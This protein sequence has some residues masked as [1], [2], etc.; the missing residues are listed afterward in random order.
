[1]ESDKIPKYQD[2]IEKKIPEGFSGHI[3]RSLDNPV[4]NDLTPVQKIFT[5]LP[6]KNNKVFEKK[7]NQDLP[8][9][10]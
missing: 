5:Q 1:M 8:L 2:F 4:K 7:L 10:I 6:G 3:E 9:E